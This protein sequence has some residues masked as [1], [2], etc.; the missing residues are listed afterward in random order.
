MEEN[1]ALVIKETPKYS[2]SEELI[3][4]ISHGVG[5]GLAIA[6]LV[7]CI[8]K[9]VT[10]CVSRG[11]VSASLYGSFLIILYLMSTL[12]HSFKSTRKVKKVFRVFDHCSIFL[13]ILGTYIPYTLI[14]LRGALGW[15]IFGIILA[16]SV[17]GIVFNS[18]SIEKFKTFSMICYLVMGWAI[19][20][21]M[22]QLCTNL[23]IRGVMLLVAGG[24]VYSIGAIIYGIGKKVKY[25]HSI[26][27]FF[28]LGGTILHFFS[29][30]LYVL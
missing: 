3:S 7:L 30:Y 26:W 4:A 27:H 13:L 9:A 15:T 24:I 8:I 5:A 10:D 6:G 17:L 25:M 21:A 22:K 28:V 19:I 29:I 12:Y 1:Y 18:I 20:F 2:L 11:V 23:D 14:T 16:S